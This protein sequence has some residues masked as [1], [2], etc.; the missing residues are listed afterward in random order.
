MVMDYWFVMKQIGE[1]GTPDGK[2]PA[3]AAGSG[4]QEQND[5]IEG[6]MERIRT[7]ATRLKVITNIEDRGGLC[8]P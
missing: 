2:P 4:F 5:T 3:P 1:N 7:F 8:K 6:T